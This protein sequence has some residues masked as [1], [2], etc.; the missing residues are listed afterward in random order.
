MEEH[1]ASGGSRK[2][3]WVEQKQELAKVLKIAWPKIYPIK[4]T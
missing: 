2:N 4:W 1:S 3:G